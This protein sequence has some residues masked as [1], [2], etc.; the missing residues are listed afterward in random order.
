MTVNPDFGQV[1]VDPAQVNLSAIETRSRRSG[2]SSSKVPRS[3]TSAPAA[4][5]TCSTRVASAA[6]RSCCRRRRRRRC[7]R[8]PHPRRSEAVG[9]HAAG[10]SV[11]VLNALT[12]REEALFATSGQ[13]RPRHAEPLTNY[14]VGRLRRDLRGGQSV[15]GGMLTMVHRDLDT[16]A[17]VRQLR[18]LRTPAASTSATNGRSAPGC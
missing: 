18:S 17:P 8:G 2:R 16:D 7:G 9:P 11:G 1:E 15:V 5:T 10:W 12:G 4:A 3:S 6:R 13:R 14:F